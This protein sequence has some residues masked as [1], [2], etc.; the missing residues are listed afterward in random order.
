MNPFSAR[1]YI[2]GSI[3]VA[4]M[5]IF[6][7]RLF[8]IQVVNTSYKLSADNNSRRYVTQYPARGL[9]YDRN[10][11]LLVYNEAAYDLMVTPVQVRAF[12]TLD[13]CTTLGISPQ[14]LTDGLAAARR[15]SMYR[16]SVLVKQISAE[17]YA[18]FQEKLHKFPGFFVQVRTLRKYS[19]KMASH[20]LGYVG[21]VDDAVIQRD[22]YYKIGD[23]MGISGL[24][25]TYEPYLRG[26]KGVNIFLVDVH[27]RIKGSYLNGRFDTA[28]VVGSN[29]FTT[30]DAELQA[31]G[32]FLMEGMRGS[33]VALEPHTGEVLSLVTMPSYDPALLVG[34]VRSSNYTVLQMDADKPLFNRALMAKYPPGSTFKIINGL[35]GLEESVVFPGTTYSCAM[36][37]HAGNLRIGCHAHSSPLNFAQAVQNSCNAYFCHVYRNTL[38]DKKFG[39]ITPAYE[40]WRQHLLSFG[41]GRRLGIDFPNELAGNVPGP[42]YF[43]RFYGQNR[44]R[45]L[46]IISMA[47]GQGELGTTPL[48][49]A[50][51]AAIMANKG[52]FIT[53][54]MVK[55]IEG[56][57]IDRKYRQKHISNVDSIHFE[58]II[59]GMELA[60]NGGAGST[61]R[62]AALKDI[63]VCGKT[64][65]A[66]NPHGKD[67]SIFIAFAPKENPKIAIAVYVENAGF[68]AT[69]AAPIASLMIEKYL[70]DTITRPWIEQHVR[71]FNIY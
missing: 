38:E 11:K 17:N 12:D 31:Y 67:H 59:Q 45:A 44:W 9:I 69:W 19:T 63:V 14:L 10:G 27:N 47:I 43:D 52:Y 26:K 42:E 18:V 15:Y 21:E 62:I 30:L 64:G 68:G 25:S 54:H 24:E 35:I 34:R 70:T 40:N 36:G 56:H 71:N 8:Y 28:A 60:V 53:P 3:I 57:E 37:Y 4:V 2:I 61:A 48:Q 32:E 33:V 23:Y 55:E 46:T 16:P 39:A 66:Q 65:T 22:A 51:M 20:V 5:L 6:A 58:P 49:M 7:T 13:F 1:K 50:N 41:F 29:I